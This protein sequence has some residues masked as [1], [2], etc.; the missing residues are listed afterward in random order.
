ME[1]MFILLFSYLR[2][3]K[4]ERLKK[5]AE[6]AKFRANESLHLYQAKQAIPMFTK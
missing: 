5:V 1:I 4:S 2:R 6:A 3:M